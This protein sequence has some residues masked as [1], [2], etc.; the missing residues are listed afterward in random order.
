MQSH[1]R[2]TFSQTIRSAG[3]TKPADRIFFR[4]DRKQH[5]LSALSHKCDYTVVISLPPSFLG[6]TASKFPNIT[7]L[8]TIL[9][10]SNIS[11]WLFFHM[12]LDR[13]GAVCIHNLIMCYNV[14]IF[15]KPQSLISDLYRIGRCFNNNL[16]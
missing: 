12:L 9:Q 4:L 3:V 15:S 8:R 14:H 16:K 10:I 2:L 1:F 7:P 6:V 11:N 5:D 13:I